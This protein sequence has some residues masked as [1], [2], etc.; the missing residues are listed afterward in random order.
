[1]RRHGRRPVGGH[2]HYRPQGA[3]AGKRSGLL[4]LR[5]EIREKRD[6]GRSGD[7]ETVADTVPERDAMPGAGFDVSV[8]GVA[9]GAA[10]VGSG[11]A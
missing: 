11:S 5:R 3:G 9:T 10:T 7:T 6:V 2:D 1:M 8:E 4:S